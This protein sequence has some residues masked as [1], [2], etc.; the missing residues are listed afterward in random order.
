MTWTGVAQSREPQPRGNA[1]PAGNLVR[2]RATV[3][4]KLPMVGLNSC[5]G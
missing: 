3:V 1:S 2:R 5:V 4:V